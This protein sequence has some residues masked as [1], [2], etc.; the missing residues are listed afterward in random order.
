MSR[1]L[2]V[3]KPIVPPFDDGTKNLVRDL[4]GA[5]GG[6]A[7]VLVPVGAP[8]AEP[9][10]GKR[11]IYGRGEEGHAISRRGA[12]RLL[13]H[14]FTA[15]LPPVLHWFFTPSPLSARLPSLVARARRRRTVWTIPS[16]PAPGLR[17][18]ELAGVDRL[19]VFSAGTR[20]AL[21]AAG[22]PPERIEVVSP[23]LRPVPPPSPARVAA[24]RTALGLSGRV[25]SFVGDLGEGRGGGELLEAFAAAR[26]QDDMLLVAARPKGQGAHEARQRLVERARAL[27]LGAKVRF[28]GTVADMPALLAASDVVALP[29]R[30]LEAKVDVPLVLLEALSL[31]RPVLVAAGSSA[32]VLADEGAAVAASPTPAALG[33]A[34][35]DL[36]GSAER[37]AALGRRGRELVQTR[38]DP[39]AVAEQHRMLYEALTR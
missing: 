31:G 37:R 35:R 33:E 2:F 16:R 34:L 23:W 24:L 36:W 22:A 5:L 3:S 9:A 11:A 17:L 25:T 39:T 1:V 38:H 21:L 4:A 28:E 15:R 14:L 26:E 6:L 20:I 27:G 19:L 32:A 8:D 12:A 10:C 18:D 30:R 13:L 29:A 7:E